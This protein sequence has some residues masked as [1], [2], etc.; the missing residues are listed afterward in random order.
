MA[1]GPI[2]TKENRRRVRRAKAAVKAYPVYDKYDILA[3]VVDLLTDLL[4]YA[5]DQRL[6]VNEII[7]SAKS[8]FQEERPSYHETL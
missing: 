7:E 3:S 8:H 1:Q 2:T 4:H 5:E 6:D